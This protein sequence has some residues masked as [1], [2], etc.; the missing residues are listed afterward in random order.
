M[1]S[2]GQ[3]QYFQELERCLEKL[4]SQE[5]LFNKIAE[6][7]FESVKVNGVWHV[8]GSG[9]SV[10]SAEELF[11][12]AGG[13]ACV[14]P[15]FEEALMPHMGPKRVGPLERTPGIGKIIFA[16]N[17]FQK[18]EPLLLV[19][20]SGIN[21]S[22]VELAQE[23]GQAGLYTFAIMSLTHSKAAP[24]RSGKKLYEVVEDVIDTGT[25]AG[26]ACVALS[27]SDLKV[28]PLSSVISLAACE[29]LVV[30]V[31][32]LF[33]E[34]GLE[35]PVYKSANMPG[36]DERNKSL[37]AKYRPRIRRL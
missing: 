37:E 15:I 35:A 2:K 36:G 33:L 27:G 6:K 3:L 18:G 32:E 22:T 7:I 8:F 25:P 29:L 5:S 34:K 28:A 1:K 14:N 10:M 12:R 19:S 26:D 11:H 31:V 21:P 9:H 23:A 24:S 16:A 13:L 4:R 17:D 20:N 30:R